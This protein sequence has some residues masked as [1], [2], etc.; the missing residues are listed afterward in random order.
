MRTPVGYGPF[1]IRYHLISFILG[2]IF[3]LVGVIVYFGISIPY[4]AAV[5]S[6]FG[7]AQSHAYSMAEYTPFIVLIVGI[8][9]AVLGLRKSSYHRKSLSAIGIILIVLG[10][11]GVIT[12]SGIYLPQGISS[13]ISTIPN[14]TKL[15]IQYSPL[16]ILVAGIIMVL[17]SL[18]GPL[19]HKDLTRVPRQ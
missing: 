4:A 7:Q 10:A 13:A 2:I 19:V 1:Y 11:L 16:A 5:K 17:L 9:I 3:A 8:I 15:L 6:G 14:Y 12:Y 18:R